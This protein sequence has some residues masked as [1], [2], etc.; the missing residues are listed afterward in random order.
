MACSSSSECQ[1]PSTSIRPISDF[2]SSL[3]QK[4]AYLKEEC[5][6]SQL[7]IQLVP[8][9]LA[10]TCLGDLTFHNLLSSS[11]QTVLPPLPELSSCLKYSSTR[12]NRFPLERGD[13]DTGIIAVCF[14]TLIF[15]KC[16]FNIFSRYD[17]GKS[18][19]FQNL[20][21]IEV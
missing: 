8:H 19:L 7:G 21:F 14:F 20:V 3:G 4:H 10:T 13:G 17:G 5:P 16:L 12:L 15:Y 11:K 1:L 2:I 6:D 18:Y 9:H